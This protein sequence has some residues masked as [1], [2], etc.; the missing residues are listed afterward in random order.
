[1]QDAWYSSMGNNTSD[2]HVYFQISNYK[3]LRSGYEKGKLIGVCGLHYIIWHIRSAEVSIFIAE[4]E[5]KGYGTDALKELCKYGFDEL[6]MHKLWAEIFDNNPAS[7]HLF[8]KVGFV[9]E[10][11]LRHNHFSGGKYGDS[12]RLSMLEEEWRK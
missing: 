1:M 3:Y 7:H 5:G 10:G 12:F 6:N 4:G 8:K 9:D 11:V 2:Q